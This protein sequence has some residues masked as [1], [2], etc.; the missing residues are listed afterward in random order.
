MATSY[1]E[2]LM[3][4]EPLEQEQLVGLVLTC[5]AHPDV[6]IN[7]LTLDFWYFLARELEKCV[8]GGVTP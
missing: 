1:M 8:G 5:T 3:A 6:A 7:S 4:P 2:L